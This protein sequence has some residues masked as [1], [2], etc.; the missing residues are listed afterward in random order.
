[1]KNIILTFLIVILL[2]VQMAYA[3][4]YQSLS[5][6]IGKKVSLH[7]HYYIPN[8]TYT[9]ENQV[10]KNVVVE[11]TTKEYRK[12]SWSTNNKSIYPE[13]LCYTIHANSSECINIKQIIF[14]KEI[15]E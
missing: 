6:F 4:D 1:M 9:D 3:E 13:F 14:I 11:S 5:R 2:L 8:G 7:Y 15:K 12:A 10:W